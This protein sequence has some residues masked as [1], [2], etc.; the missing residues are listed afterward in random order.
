MNARIYLTPIKMPSQKNL[1]KA[2]KFKLCYQKNTEN[3]NNNA[4]E[5]GRKFFFFHT[6]LYM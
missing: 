5:N 6:Y 1:A 4:T 3:F 2:E